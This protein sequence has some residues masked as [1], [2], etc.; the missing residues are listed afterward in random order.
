[1]EPDRSDDGQGERLPSSFTPRER[2]V[3]TLIIEGLTNEQV[4]RKLFISLSTVKTHL[5]NI[6]AKAQV[7]NR[8]ALVAMLHGCIS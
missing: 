1:M 3:A 6:Y 4:A 2:E 5:Q 8:T 7:P